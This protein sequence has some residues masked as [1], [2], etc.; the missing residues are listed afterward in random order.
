MLP[1]FKLKAKNS[2]YRTWRGFYKS[3]RLKYLGLTS[4]MRSDERGDND[5]KKCV[6]TKWDLDKKLDYKDEKRMQTFIKA[7]FLMLRDI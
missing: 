3:C 1:L 2:D 7:H 4:D 6:T 5:R